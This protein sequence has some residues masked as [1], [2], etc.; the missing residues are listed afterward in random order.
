MCKEEK[1]LYIPRETIS[2][3]LYCSQKEE[4]NLSDVCVWL[5]GK[6]GK[7]WKYSR[8]QVWMKMYLEIHFP[9]LHWR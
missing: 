5:S 7:R 2:R 4:I 3:A 6:D 9:W 1:L 8:G